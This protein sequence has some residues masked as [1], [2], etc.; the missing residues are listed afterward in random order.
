MIEVSA[1]MPNRRTP[2]V[3]SSLD[4]H[5]NA[6]EILGI[7]AQLPNIAD[8]ALPALADAWHNT[9]F[10]AEARRRA[11]EPDAPLVLEALARFELVQ[12]LFAEEIR[13]GEDYLTV[14]PD[15]AAMAL[16][17]IRDAIAAAYARPILSA[18]E[19]EALIKAWRTVYPTDLSVAPN[20]GARA[21]DVTSLL[22]AL[23]KLSS[24]CHD[25]AAAGEFASI[26]AA[27]SVLDEDIRVA[28]RDE[29]WH[30]AVLTSQ[31]RTWQ[32]LRH[33]AEER[34]SRGY[35]RTCRTRGYDEETARVLSLCVDAA[36]GLLVA[37]SLEDDIVDVLTAP[38]ECLIPS[39]RPA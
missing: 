22:S 33:T 21:S 15:V 14:E 5:P 26:L 3:I 34:S 25:A 20:F 7:T 11:L 19:H 9:T 23:P 28:A 2:V 39:Q 35:C 27:G 16:K 38:V 10:L 30:A 29:A 18:G 6:A 1:T 24:R 13:G 32:L 8:Q 12:A 31:R 17:A 37:G 4:S 36:C